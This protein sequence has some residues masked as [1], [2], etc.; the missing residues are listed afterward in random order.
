MSFVIGFYHSQEFRNY[1]F[2]AKSFVCFGELN[3]N[4]SCEVPNEFH[5]GVMLNKGLER[6]RKSIFIIYRCNFEAKWILRK[7]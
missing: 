2:N 7:L 4:I 5:S 1:I 3:S 6:R